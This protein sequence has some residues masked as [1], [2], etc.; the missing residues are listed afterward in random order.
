MNTAIDRIVALFEQLAPTGLGGLGQIYAP[1]ARFVDPFNDVTGVDAITRIFE[2]MFQT[3]ENPR[4]VVI[5]QVVGQQ[6]CFLTWDF[7][8]QF[9]RFG[10]GVPHTIHGASHLF[11]DA[12]GLVAVHRDYWDAALLYEAMPVIGAPMRWLR[13]QAAA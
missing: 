8:F 1:N 11:L 9:R 5:D 6:Q 13:R 12:A 4:F 10:N 3:L 2:H 7:H